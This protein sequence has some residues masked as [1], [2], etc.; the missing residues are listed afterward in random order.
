MPRALLVLAF[1]VGADDLPVAPKPGEFPAE[2]AAREISGEL[3]GVDHVARTGTLRPDR[4][5]AQRTDDY[6]VAMPF[7]LLPYAR[8]M[9]H[10]MYAELRDVPIG[11]HLHGRFFVKE[12]PAKNQKPVFDRAL[13]LEDDFSH[14]T[15][16]KKAWRV[17]TA[18]IDKSKLTVTGVL[19]DGTA[20]PK[21]T[22]FQIVPSTRV[23]KGRGYGTLKELAPGMKILANL[24]VCTLKGP[25]RCL[26]LWLDDE[27]R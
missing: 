7:T 25:G 13:S 12:A 8:T 5:D 23:W 3:I 10:G 21:P 6:D 24:T 11:T 27:S 20:D 22:V 18:E 19:E 4:T 16:L 14:F 15:R 26:D 9:V 2:G 1:L 17:D